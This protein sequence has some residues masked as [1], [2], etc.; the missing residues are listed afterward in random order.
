[1]E[2]HRNEVV[3]IFAGY[4]DKM[5]DFLAQNEGLRSRIAFHLDF[6]DY[7]GEEMEA[8]LEQ[9]V[10]Q[11]KYALDTAARARC[12]QF[13]KQAV[14]RANFGNGRFVRN[15]L[16]HAI[17]NQALRLSDGHDQECLPAEE[18]KLLLAEDFESDHEMRV[19][20]IKPMGICLL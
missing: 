5:Q 4:P 9:M 7:S 2:N 13:L 17:M 19:P 12:V 16:D 8:I 6:P 10:D 11:R 14:T 3:V 15:M 1:M 20:K 18:L